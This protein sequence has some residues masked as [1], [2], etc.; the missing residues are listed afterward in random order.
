MGA[1]AP[2]LRDLN[3]YKRSLTPVEKYVEHNAFYLSLITGKE[4]SY[5]EDWVRRQ[6]KERRRAAGRVRNPIVLHFTRTENGDRIM[7]RTPLTQYI[8]NIRQERLVLA[9]TG[10]AYIPKSV[11]KSLISNFMAS[12]VKIRSKA[13]KEAQAAEQLS[14]AAKRDGNAAEELKQY[15][16]YIFKENEQKNRKTYNNAMSGTFGVFGTALN[17]PTAHSTLTSTTRNVSAVGNASNEK[18][19]CGNR[20]YRNYHVTMNNVIAIAYEAD[21]TAIRNVMDKYG[22]HYPSPEEAMSVIRYSSDRYWM[23][24]RGWD[25]LKRLLT[26]LS[27]VQRAA[28]VYVSDLYHM[29]RFNPELVRSLL[30]TLATPVRDAHMSRDE[31]IQTLRQSDEQIVNFLHQ[32]NI[33]LVKGIGKDYNKLDDAPLA[34]LAAS[35]DHVAESVKSYRDLFE[36]F[37]LTNIMPAT[38]SFLPEMM[39]SC[40]VL[41]DTD[42]TMFSVDEFISWEF[43]SVVFNDQSFAFGG[44]V[45]YIATQCIGHNLAL[46]SGNI[47]V[48]QADMFKLAMKPEYVFPTHSQTAVA[49]HY[50]ATMLVKEGNVYDR[51]KYEFKGVHMKSSAVPR[52]LVEDGHALAKRVSETVEANGKISLHE[53]LKHV[54]D[55]ERSIIASINRSESRY[56]RRLKVKPKDTYSQDPTR[57]NYRHHTYWQ[58]IWAPKYGNAPE[59]EYVT[60]V[61][62]TIL[63][64]PS[65]LKPW[66]MG[67]QDPELK[68]R[69]AKDMLER[70]RKQMKTMYLPSGLVTS[71]GI[72]PEIMQIVDVR[73]IVLDM[74]KIHRM[75]LET[76]GFT[77]KRN[78]MIHELG[79]W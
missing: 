65:M 12:N 39:R 26:R 36:A 44:A 78:M 57:S 41:S 17:N 4:M 21:A 19:I 6:L 32:A 35:C 25:K 10:T 49:K 14:A 59:P 38:T 8:K 33:T 54:A 73:R 40:V 53:T 5:C 24:N 64:G 74:T 27:D 70:D 9:P 72:P 43:G 16:I 50:W 20:H 61:V 15:E 22:M 28:V 29:R 56:F 7:E 2:F 11:R 34:Q 77:I 68:A 3:F 23:D 42:S 37:F 76:I 18:L 1:V 13:K 79:N 48:D 52:E 60:Y 30:W 58:N 66:I 31:A 55:I 67:I 46:L 63:K 51:V 45:A 62:P 71:Y 69:L 47:G 75:I